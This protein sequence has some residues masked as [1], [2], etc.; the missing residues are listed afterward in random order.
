MRRKLQLTPLFEQLFLEQLLIKPARLPVER[1]L[2]EC[3]TEL[4]LR[5]LRHQMLQTAP[6]F[7][8]VTLILD[9]NDRRPDDVLNYM[10]RLI[11]RDDVFY[12]HFP[13][14]RVLAVSHII[15]IIGVIDNIQVFC[16]S[17]Y[18]S[19]WMHGGHCVVSGITSRYVGREKG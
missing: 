5:I 8:L 11:A 7:T 15:A 4:T 14:L 6:F 18:N 3:E 19:M 10:Q 1:D 13:T 16:Y 2:V 12:V 9:F 17:I